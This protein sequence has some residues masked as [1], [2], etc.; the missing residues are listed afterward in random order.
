MD[1][2]ITRRRRQPRSEAS[3]SSSTQGRA[4]DD[5][6]TF[7]RPLMDRWS[8]P[9]MLA[10]PPDDGEYTF[11]WVREY[12]NGQADGRNVQ[13]RL[14]EGWVRVNITDL[15]DDL[16]M[17][18]DE[19][20]KGDGYARTGGLILMKMPIRFA[21]QRREYYRKKAEGAAY[22]ADA[23]QGLAGRNY[24]QEDRGSRG[25]E[26]AAAKQLLQQMAK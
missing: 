2:E 6:D 18:A 26:G 16:L 4:R 17:V 15:P 14:R 3:R 9:S 13:M 25:I 8:P 22:A 24:V 7:E 23:L 1:A 10:V 11:R 20:E 12:V 21:E 19:D 5:T